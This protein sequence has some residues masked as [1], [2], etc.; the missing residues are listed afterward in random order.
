MNKILKLFLLLIYILIDILT[1]LIN[2][3]KWIIIIF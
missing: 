2:L 1:I 3:I